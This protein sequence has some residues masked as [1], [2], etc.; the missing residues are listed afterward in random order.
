MYKKRRYNFMDS[1]IISEENKYREALKE[2][3]GDVINN[4][5]P[6][7]RKF[8]HLTMVTDMINNQYE[9]FANNLRKE[10]KNNEDAKRA[11]DMFEITLQRMDML[12]I[13]INDIHH[14]YIKDTTVIEEFNNKILMVSWMNVIVL[15]M[16]MTKII[17]PVLNIIISQNIRIDGDTELAEHFKEFLALMRYMTNMSEEFESY[18]NKNIHY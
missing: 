12:H 18:V 5:D 4:L 7:N 9:V 14:E 8:A 3:F 6:I 16:Y 11:F 13:K 2:K 1:K 15:C 10:S 17:L